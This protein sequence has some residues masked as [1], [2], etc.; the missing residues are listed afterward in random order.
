MSLVFQSH[1]SSLFFP[2][3]SIWYFKWKEMN[4]DLFRVLHVFNLCNGY[5]HVS[6]IL[7][8]PLTF[9]VI[10]SIASVTSNNTTLNKMFKK[11]T[12]CHKMSQNVNKISK[13][14]N[15]KTIGITIWNASYLVLVHSFIHSLESKQ[16]FVQ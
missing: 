16:T 3:T 11:I 14:S 5:I 12:K 9:S 4:L 15:V 13:F 6:H 10:S 1:L 2:F 8:I 7:N